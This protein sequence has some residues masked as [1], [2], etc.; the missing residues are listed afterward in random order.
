[1][2]VGVESCK[3]MTTADMLHFQSIMRGMKFLSE[4]TFQN[5][6]RHCGSTVYRIVK[7][8]DGYLAVTSQPGLGTAFDIYLPV[9]KSLPSTQQ[10]KISTEFGW[11]ETI[12]FV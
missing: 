1:M 8:A 7:Q 9:V 11:G 4:S 3:L 12:L 6:F 10:K 5:S 2:V